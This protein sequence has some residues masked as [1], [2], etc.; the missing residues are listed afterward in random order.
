MAHVVGQPK[1]NLVLS[2]Q[3]TPGHYEQ[4]SVGFRPVIL[5]DFFRIAR[6]K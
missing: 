4:I 1:R 3:T 2:E 6:R 5:S